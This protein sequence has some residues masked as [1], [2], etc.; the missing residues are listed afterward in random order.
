MARYGALRSASALRRPPHAGFLLPV[1]AIFAIP[2]VSSFALLFARPAHGAFRRI[3]A[4]L[5]YIFAARKYTS[6]ASR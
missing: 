3:S 5:P 6:A 2:A 1:S 4:S